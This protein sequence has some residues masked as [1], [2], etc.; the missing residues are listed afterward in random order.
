[1][2]NAKKA[3]RVLFMVLLM[4]VASFGIGIGNV[5]NNNRERYMDNEIR[6]ENISKKDQEEVEEE[7]KK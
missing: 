1:M 6:T 3:L 4:I 5:L 2:E 7:S